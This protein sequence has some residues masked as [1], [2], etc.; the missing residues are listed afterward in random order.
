MTWDGASAL[1]VQ[2]LV[3]AVFEYQALARSGKKV[4]GIIDADTPVA[5]RRKLRDQDLF[6]LLIKRT[7]HDRPTWESRADMVARTM[8]EPVI[9][10]ANMLTEFSRT[11]LYP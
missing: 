8:A 11:E 2:V 6:E 5:A 10:D 4:K 1:S 9:T 3:M 7:W